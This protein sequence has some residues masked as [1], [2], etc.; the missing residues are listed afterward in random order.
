MRISNFLALVGAVA[1]TA[2][3]AGPEKKLGRGIMNVTEFAR[4]GEIR[5]SMEQT[6]LWENTDSA[7]TT[8][9][10]RGMNRSL[11]RTAIGVYEIATFPIPSYGPVLASTNRIYPDP[12]VR[13]RNFPFG[14][15]S[16]SEYPTY[17]DSY[18]PG[19][20]SDSI[21]STDTALGFSGGDVA[22][23][24]PGSRFRIFDN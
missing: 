15:M 16:L 3:C 24:V 10:I 9:F 19:I 4:G 2:G 1:L 23:F 11:A 6:Y 12:N 20:L 13:N 8:G 14:G 5:R 18:K 7:Y 22:P 17:P 21:F